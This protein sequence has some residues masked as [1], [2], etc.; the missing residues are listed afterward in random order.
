M[1][2]KVKI[3]IGVAALA[4]VIAGAS[5]AYKL[6]S[7][8]YV[9]NKHISMPSAAPA[10]DAA[11]TDETMP[12]PD[13]IVTDIDGNEYKLSDFFGKPIVLNFWASWC[14][15][16]KAELP[17]FNN[18]YEELG[19]EVTFM[20]VDL[21]DGQSETVAKGSKYIE[22][23]GY[24]FPVYYDTAQDAANTYGISA[25]PTT[26]FIHSDGN[27]I[28]GHQGQIDEVVLREGISLI[29]D[30]NDTM[31][32]AEYPSPGKISV[33]QAKEML[34]R[35]ADIILLDVRTEDEYKEKHI[36]GAILI[37]DYEIASR[38]KSELPDKDAVILLYCRSGRRSANAA[39][40]L[41]DMGYSNVYDFG[42]I[43]DWPYETV[44]G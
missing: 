20:M 25:I 3:I 27:V 16:C 12:A 34:S 7:E 8:N 13:F 14:P 44:T 41:N 15:P 18:V 24:S 38:A 4:A 17:D 42:G 40:E 21:T 43:L 5:F 10:N 23:S 37:P 9:D 22:E 26:L 28:A 35:N 29:Y 32:N 6:L 19:K 2:G 39:K 31:E 11:Q 36:E 30:Q 1:N 33:E